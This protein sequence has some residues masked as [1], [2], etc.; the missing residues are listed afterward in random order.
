MDPLP[1]VGIAQNGKADRVAKE[2]I[3]DLSADTC[4]NHR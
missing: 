3:V 1:R 2:V 4:T